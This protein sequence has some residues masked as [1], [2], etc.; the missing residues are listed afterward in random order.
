MKGVI[1]AAGVA[2]R[3]RPLT[4][5]RPKCL[6]EIG[7]K[8]ILGLTLE[9]LAAERITDIV[10]VTGY[11]ED[12]IRRFVGEQF[13]ALNVAFVTNER[14]E[15][16]NNS[17][18]L[19]LTRDAVAGDGIVLLDSDIVFDRRILHLLIDAPAEDCLAMVG[20]T[21]L[22]DEEIKLKLGPGHS[23]LRI[24]KDVPPAEAAGESIGIEKMS[25]AFMAQLYAALDRLIVDRKT[26]TLFYEAAFQDVIEGGRAMTAIDVG[27]T[28]CIEI[29]TPDDLAVARTIGAF[30]GTPARP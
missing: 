18:S 7:G 4:D 22:A 9:N 13:P 26:V 2:S 24:G 14:Y 3:L 17:Y 12:Q 20:G 11:R 1:L 5:S 29:D 19:W 27:T 28:P 6:L 30:A 21:P 10:I 15:T 25:A 8:T 23:V 16:T